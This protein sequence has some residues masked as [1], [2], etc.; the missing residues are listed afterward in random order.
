MT[1]PRNLGTGTKLAIYGTIL[2]GSFAAAAGL[3][4]AVGPA[5]PARK[6]RECHDYLTLVVG[7]IGSDRL[8]L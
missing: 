6:T 4:A 3:A 5:A 7:W 8:A 1:S 2:A